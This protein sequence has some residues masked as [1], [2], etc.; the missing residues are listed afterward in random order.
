MSITWDEVTAMASE[1]STLPVAAQTEVLAT[2]N[3]LPSDIWGSTLKAGQLALARHL[4][5]IGQ[6]RSGMGGAIT[7]ATLGSASV[8]YASASVSSGDSLE[9]TSWGQE[10]IRLVYTLPYARMALVP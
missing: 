9:S 8:S 2:A 7:S 6:R 4:G 3:A 10:Y 1:L 5:T